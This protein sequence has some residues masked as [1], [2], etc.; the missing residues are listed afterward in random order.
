[1][2]F[3]AVV[4]A[5]AGGVFGVAYLLGAAIGLLS[6]GG[7]GVLLLGGSVPLTASVGVLL[8]T[9]A[10]LLATGHR[11]GRYIGVVTYAAVA[12]FG[13]PSLASPEPF[14][15]AQAGLALLFACY[16]TVRDP[17]PNADRSHVDEST[18]ATRLGS[19]IR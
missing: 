9:A 16:L 19:T 3:D 10:G 13:R 7:N 8:A 15:A 11:Y 18:S 17:I 4:V 5:A 12:V 14:P 2:R 6:D 1:M